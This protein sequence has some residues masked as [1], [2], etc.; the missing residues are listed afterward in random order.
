MDN[1]GRY[2]DTKTELDAVSPSMCVAK[3]NQ[4]TVHLGTG[5]TH[6][7]H[8]PAPHKIPLS[9]IVSNPSALHNTNFK[10]SQRNLMLNGERPKE[11]DYCWRVE[12]AHIGETENGVFS[13]RITKSSEA[14]A[15]P[16]IQT[17]KNT[18][19]TANVNPKYMEVSFDATCN[20]KCAYCG[21]SFSTTWRQE[22]EEHGPYRLGDGALYDLG[23]LE[24][25]GQLP[26]PITKPNPYIDAFWQWW[27]DAVK[28]LEIFRITGGEPLL[29][30]QVFRVLDYLIEN[31]QP[32]LEFNINSNLCVPKEIFN[33]FIEKMQIIKEKNAVKDFKVY[34]SN[35]AHG[36]QAEYIRYGLDYQQWLAN[37]HRILAE[38]PDSKLT[39]MAA[40]NFLSLP[41]F[42]LMM[43][44]VIDMKWKYTIQ[45]HRKN[46]VGLDVP[47]I[48]W[49]EHLAAWVGDFNKH[50]PYVEDAVT[51]MFRNIH[52]MF[53]P[54]LCG[55]GFF[56]YEVNRFERLYYTI[57]E[58]MIKVGNDKPRMQKLRGEFAEYIYQYDQRKG[59]NF[60]EVFP[61][62]GDFYNECK[63]YSKRFN[64]GEFK[65]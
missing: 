12:D 44:D 40:Y 28:D 26:V 37:C 43:D 2:R 39:I 18:P 64:E 1:L 60:V 53:W 45:P 30:K 14:W 56:D 29:S 4:V 24:K 34:T 7:C 23:W 62:F 8:H 51:H 46:P 42:K 13:D 35:E 47:Y 57:R 49:P 54:P 25:T 19:W 27:P 15:L 33:K 59:T 16:H 36:A 11:C 22:I 61:E 38:I 20:L 21:P 6:S 17:I 48:R 31:P 41:S 65:K 9:E 52:Q 10:K 5:F 55:K 63:E 3:W 32:Q 58:E 50:L